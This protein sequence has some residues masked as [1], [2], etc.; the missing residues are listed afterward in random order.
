MSLSNGSVSISEALGAA[1]T[2]AFGIT[3]TEF[4][5]LPGLVVTCTLS[6]LLVLPLVSRQTDRKTDS[7]DYRWI[8][9]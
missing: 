9:G 8:S 1:T 6:R 7:C 2:R 4:G 5:N 3:A